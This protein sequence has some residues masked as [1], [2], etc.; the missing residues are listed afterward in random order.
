MAG[1]PLAES[2]TRAADVAALTRINAESIADAIG[3][4]RPRSVRRLIEWALRPSARPFALQLAQYDDRVGLV[5]LSSGARWLLTQFAGRLD[6]AGQEH[7]PPEGPVL[8]VANHPGLSDTLALFASIGRDDLRIVAADRPF[9]RSLPRTSH[10]LLYLTD[11]PG[12]RLAALR[13]LRAHLRSGGAA[14]TFPSG[15]IE[16]DPALHP[17][18]AAELSGWSENLVTLARLCP[19][20]PIVPCVVSGVLSPE[21]QLHPLT[22][23]RRRPEDREWLGATLQMLRPSYQQVTVRVAFGPVAQALESGESATNARW[24]AQRVQL[25]VRQLI[26]QPPTTWATVLTRAEAAQAPITQRSYAGA[27]Q[28]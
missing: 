4:P 24:L 22:G 17:D 7:I 19:T 6:V 27:S 5:G 15:C 18:R 3:L 10:H 12:Q 28:A 20:M 23:I 21:A 2:L 13:G 14:L 25:A 1:A 8:I 9:L 16:P 11:E 26:R